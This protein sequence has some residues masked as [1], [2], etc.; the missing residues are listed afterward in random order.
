MKIKKCRSC[1][2]KKLVPIISLGNHCV[3]DFVEDGK[4]SVKCPL[5]LVLCNKCKLLQLEHNAPDESM[6]GDQYWYKSAINPTIR[7]DLK[8]IVNQVENLMDLTYGDYVLDIG[9]ND[10]TMMEYY[11]DGRAIG[12]EPSKN[13]CDEARDKG[14]EVI[15]D[16]FNK[17][18]YRKHFKKKAKVITAISMFYDLDD[19][20]KFLRDINDCLEKDGLFI[21]QQNYLVKMLENT[22][23]DNI[24]HEHREYYS[25]TSLNHLLKRHNLEVFDVILNGING[26]SIRTYI[27]KKRSKLKGKKGAEER[28]QEIIDH[29]KKLKLHTN[30]PYLEFA[31]RGREIKRKI[32]KFV[33]QELKKGKIICGSGAST[34]GNTT[35]QYFGLTPKHIKCIGD[36]NPEKFGKKTVGQLIPIN[37]PKEVQKLKPDYLFVLIWYF[38]NDIIRNQKTFLEKGGKLIVPFPSPRII[39]KKREVKL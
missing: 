3:I 2:N 13:V 17:R 18:A 11:K 8:D 12:F 6:W 24:C 5:N 25:L 34:K 20:N 38:L 36:K 19:P 33:K 29:E 27:R 28:V 30:K 39:S 23:L 4:K 10:G 37:S 21:I 1:G 9:C 32:M 15:N 14:F 31:K 26:G 22:G 35:L 7:A 16:F